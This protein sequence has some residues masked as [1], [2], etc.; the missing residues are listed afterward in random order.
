MESTVFIFLPFILFYFVY[1]F[2]FALKFNRADT[3]YSKKQ[4]LMHNII[5]WIFP[6]F[7]IILLKFMSTASSD[8]YKNKTKSENCSPYEERN[9]NMRGG[10]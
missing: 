3:Y 4:K 1:T 6:F 9:P 2:L 8:K 5:I 10:F 7:W